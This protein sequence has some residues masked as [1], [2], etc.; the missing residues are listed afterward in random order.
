MKTKDALFGIGLNLHI[1]NIVSPKSVSVCYF[2]IG[3]YSSID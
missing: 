2:E 3:W 1:K